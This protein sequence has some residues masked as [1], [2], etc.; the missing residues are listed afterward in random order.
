MG[1]NLGKDGSV[2]YQFENK[3]SLIIAKDKYPDEDQVM[4]DALDAGCEDIEIS[5]DYYEVV[6]DPSEYHKVLQGLT[7]AEYEF[8]D[9]SLGPEAMTFAQLTDPDQIE[10]IE[11]LLDGLE[12][13]DDV[14]DVFHNWEQEEE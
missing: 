13:I 12:E 10:K 2:A 5:D 8:A 9:V 7:A 3:G 1:G 6:T 4:L 11:K 14:Q